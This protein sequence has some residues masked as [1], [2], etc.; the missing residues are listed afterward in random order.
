M[1]MVFMTKTKHDSLPAA[2]RQAID[3]NSGESLSRALGASFEERSL[4]SRAP[5]AA[6]P[7]KHKIVALTATQNDAW[8]ATISPV[9]DNWTS[10]HPG[11]AK[12]LETYRGLLADLRASK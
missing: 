10:S 5:A 1:F 3:E 12:L 4:K 2:I 11:G 6:T 9:I 8:R 7:D